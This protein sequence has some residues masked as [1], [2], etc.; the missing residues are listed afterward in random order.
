MKKYILKEPPSAAPKKIGYKDDLNPQQYK[1]VTDSDGPV[2]VLAGAGSG[3]TRTLIYRVAYLLESGVKPEN[4]M[5]VTFTNRAAR[6]MSSRVETL[7]GKKPKGL[8][9]GTFHHIAN[10]CLRVYAGELGYT[11]DFFILDEEDSLQL[12][13]SSY[14]DLKKSF[15]QTRFPRPKI[16]QSIISFSI[17]SAASIKDVISRQYPY[18]EE[19][20]ADIERLNGFYIERKKSS[21]SMDYDDL[22]TNWLKLLAETEDVSEHYRNQFKYI[23]VDEYQDTNRLQY[24]IIRSLFSYHRNILVVGDDAQSIYSFRAAQIRNILDFPRHFENARIYKLETNYRSTKMVL[25]LA[26]ESIKNNV[27][28]Y[29]KHLISLSPK[30]PKPTLVRLKDTNQQSCFIAQRM[31]ELRQEGVP[32]GD[33]AVLFR[34]HYQAVELELELAKR[35]IPY[36]I[37]GGIRF[38]EQAHIKDVLSYLRAILNPRDEVAWKRALGLYEGFGK[39]TRDKLFSELSKY[40]FGLN[41]IFSSAFK[42][43][44]PQKANKSWQD[45]ARLMRI[46]EDEPNRDNPSNQITLIINSGYDKYVL[47]SFENARDRLKDL[48]EL[49]N[50]AHTYGSLKEFLQ[51]ITIREGFRGE[52]VLGAIKD[53]EFLVLSTIHQ[54]KGLEWEAVFIMG[55]SDGHFPHPKSMESLKNL[56]EERRLFYVAI[57]RAKTHLYMTYPMSH[58]HYRFGEI[59]SRPSLFI[60]ELP[61][62]SYK[63]WEVDVE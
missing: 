15:Y 47:N 56:E 40:S 32:L 42:V 38:F 7:L 9:C 27:E 2:L 20:T 60:E 11:R 46:L 12:I 24:E 63:L 33:I 54:A 1:V 18:F 35:N 36:I 61:Q 51:D 43:K 52:T 16:I 13:K 14:E 34:S 29:P 48:E 37:R 8:W 41:V 19:L 45:F 55:L 44:L 49:S 28:Q 50:F 31:L 17:N 4:I 58:P 26:N 30:G 21:N 10:R 62:D 22:L 3:K 57:T 59:I 6:E 39:V 23:L 53:E 5:L 25:R